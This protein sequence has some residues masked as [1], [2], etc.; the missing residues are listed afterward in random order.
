[1][2]E[3]FMEALSGE[4]NK[5]AGRKTIAAATR[6]ALEIGKKARFLANRG[7][8]LKGSTKL[9]EEIAPELKKLESQA[10]TMESKSTVKPPKPL[11]PAPIM[12]NNGKAK[13]MPSVGDKS[14]ELDKMSS[15]AGNILASI[16]MNKL[17]EGPAPVAPISITPPANTMEQRTKP[18]KPL[19][20]PPAPG[21]NGKAKPMPSIGTP[22]VPMNKTSASASEAGRV[23]KALLENSEGREGPYSDSQQ[24]GVDDPRF[25][26]GGGLKNLKGKRAPAFT[27]R[28][29]P[30]DT[31]GAFKQAQS[32]T[33]S[34]MIPKSS[35]PSYGTGCGPKYGCGLGK[36]GVG[37]GLRE[38]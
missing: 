24:I 33:P 17:G 26:G 13:P 35:N 1:M 18:P 38:K 4:L 32:I 6:R 7:A 8:G 5:V 11:T 29:N 30:T 19:T 20:P 21:V 9:G 31:P 10:K 34:K 27:D 25:G 12:G 23:V 15:A 14:V 37:C 28:F 3:Y 22:I 16:L 36:H 2:T